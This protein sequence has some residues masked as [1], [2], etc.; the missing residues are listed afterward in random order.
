MTEGEDRRPLASRSSKWAHALTAR[1]AA[2][3]I[4]PNQISQVSMLMAALAAA[5]F[6][7]AGTTHDVSRILLLIAAAAFCQLRLAC[8]LLDGMVAVEAGKGSADGA[9]WNEF[10][11]RVS[12]IIIL[13]GVGYGIGEPALGW[14]AAAF[15]LM[16]AYTRELGRASGAGN[17][18]CGPM[19]KPHRMA[20]ITFAALV[21]IFEGWWG[22]LDN[23]LTIA[24]WVIVIGTV[25]TTLRRA[26]R[27]V[28]R[29]KAGVET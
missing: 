15:A 27:I 1:L 22:A 9:F 24:L 2:T 6:Y 25:V 14:A 21:S 28:K 7:F 3:S 18:F 17:D 4:T 10:P 12:D 19:A 8:N 16:T 20:V 29:L 26:G 5:A 13:V 23:A 11:D